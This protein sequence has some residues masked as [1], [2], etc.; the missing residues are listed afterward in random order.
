MKRRS[1]FQSCVRAAAIIA[2]APQLA[3]RVRPDAVVV[4]KIDSMKLW[5]IVTSRRHE[6]PPEPLKMWME[7]TTMVNG[8][9]SENMNAGEAPWRIPY[10]E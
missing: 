1:F 6:N 5:Q 9:R 4:A 8:G 7:Y 2:L 10:Q 3:F